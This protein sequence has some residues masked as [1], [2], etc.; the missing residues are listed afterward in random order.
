MAVKNITFGVKKVIIINYC[1]LL[2]SFKTTFRYLRNQPK[3]ILVSRL[4]K[5]FLTNY[6]KPV[7]L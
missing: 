4:Y 7:W 5:L 2:K 3:N 6:D 1:I